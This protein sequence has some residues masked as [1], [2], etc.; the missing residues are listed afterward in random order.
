MLIVSSLSHKS[1]KHKIYYSFECPIG[2]LILRHRSSILFSKDCSFASRMEGSGGLFDRLR[3]L[4]WQPAL[5]PLFLSP[6]HANH[7]DLGLFPRKQY[8][9]RV[10]LVRLIKGKKGFCQSVVSYCCP[11]VQKCFSVIDGSSN[12]I[13]KICKQISYKQ[14]K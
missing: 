4:R 10:R 8:I 6:L 3:I 14:R 5:R 11:D 12:I 2:S 7:G 9:V 13:Y 1:M